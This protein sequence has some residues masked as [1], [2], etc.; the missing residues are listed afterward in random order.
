[1]SK[2]TEERLVKC[3]RACTERRKA[4]V[5]VFAERL[6]GLN[7]EEMESSDPAPVLRLVINNERPTQ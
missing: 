2:K 3:F 5:L 1:M 7:L 4:A 6:S